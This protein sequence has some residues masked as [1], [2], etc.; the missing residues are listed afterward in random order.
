MHNSFARL[1]RSVAV[2]LG[3]AVA[4]STTSVLAQTDAHSLNRAEC[5]FI[6]TYDRENETYDFASD[7]AFMAHAL[8]FEAAGCRENCFSPL[9]KRTLDIDVSLSP[10]ENLS[11]DA[12]LHSATLV[13]FFVE[14]TT[15]LSVAFRPLEEPNLTDGGTLVVFAVDESNVQELLDAFPE[16]PFLKHAIRTAVLP[17]TTCLT[18]F[19]DWTEKSEP[20]FVFFNSEHHNTPEQIASCVRE[21]AFNSL[22]LTGDLQGDDTLFTDERWLGPEWPAPAFNRFGERDYVMMRLFYRPAFEVG[23]SYE[24]TLREI[25]QIIEQE[26]K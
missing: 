8:D 7:F 19:F 13:K 1:S 24:E 6:E 20:A 5:K 4:L 18:T 15:G 25:T 26:C 21:E 17:G 16:R 22:G 12:S 14:Y 10:T 3:L 9:R 11:I 23:Q 2:S